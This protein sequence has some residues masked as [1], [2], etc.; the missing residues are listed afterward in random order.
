[1]KLRKLTLTLVSIILVTAIAHSQSREDLWE[2]DI[3]YLKTELPRKH[4]NLF[5]KIDKSIYNQKL[6]SVLNKTDKLSDIEISIALL[7]VVASVGDGHTSIYIPK[8]AEYGKLPLQLYWFSDGIYITN[9]FQQYEEMLWKKIVSVNGIPIDDVFKKLSNLI[10]KTNDAVIKSYMPGSFP[11]VCFLKYFNIMEGDLAVISYENSKGEIQSATVNSFIPS[12]NSQ[13][14]WLNKSFKKKALCESNRKKLFWYNYIDSSQV[15]YT[16]YNRCLSKEV[17]K[18]YGNKKKAKELPSFN[19]YSKDL[20]KILNSGKVD[21]LVFDMRYNP[22]GNSNQGTR[23][24]KKIADIESINQKGKI[25]VVVGRRTFSSAILNS[26]DFQNHTEAIFVGEP[27]GGRP[28]HYGEVRKFTLP[29]HG[30]TV[31][32]STKYFTHSKKDDNSFYPDHEIYITFKDYEN[33]IDPI[34]EWILKY[35]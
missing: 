5:F 9:A 12:K 27:T 8:L 25:F 29:K 13:H 26:L 10:A 6:D 1:M 28:N 11:Y 24:I 3:N 35:K 16:Q 31:N 19:K 22:G 7:E 4:K 15:L 21:K 14:K 23:L 2:K 33:G 34:M 20:L 17:L 18:Q 30:L 32:Y